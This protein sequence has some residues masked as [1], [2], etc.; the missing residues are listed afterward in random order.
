MIDRRVIVRDATHSPPRACGAPAPASQTVAHVMFLALM[1]LIV[2]GA[3]AGL[4]DLK[5]IN[6]PRYVQI[7]REINQSGSWFALTLHGVP[8]DQKPPLGFWFLA[9]VLR[10]TGDA[11]SSF[12]LRLPSVLAACLTVL[13]TY[14]LGRR[15]WGA[16]AGLIAASLLLASPELVSLAQSAKLDM[17]FTA[18]ITLALWAWLTRPAGGAPI[19]RGRALVLWGSLAAAVLTK[20]PLAILIVLPVIAADAV[21]ARSWKPL[22]DARPL[23]G[24]VIVLAPV[25]GWLFAEA[26]RVGSGFVVDQITGATLHR[27]FGKT[28]ERPLWY[29]L[30]YFPTAILPLWGFVLIG[31]AVALWRRRSSLPSSLVSL[32]VWVTVPFLVLTLARGKHTSYLLPI[33]PGCALLVGWYLED[34]LAQGRCWPRLARVFS[35]LAWFAGAASIAFGVAVLL[36]PD[37][38]WPREIHATAIAQLAMV[39]GVVL[40]GAGIWVVAD[41]HRGWVTVQGTIVAML[42]F[43][44]NGSAIINSLANATK[45]T[46][47]FGEM[48]DKLIAETGVSREVGALGRAGRA[49]HHIYGHYRVRLIDPNEGVFDNPSNLPSL[50]VGY[51]E[52]WQGLERAARAAGY[53]RIVVRSFADD[54]L[55]LY[56]RRTDAST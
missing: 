19:S 47:P 23:L 28:H 4:W 2:L 30:L 10:T 22:R 14:D 37:Y 43:V 41:R 35:G 5:G 12:A 21:R 33:L 13:L 9:A 3:T 16:R 55:R 53:R 38:F 11:V 17:M 44:L 31:A 15:Y 8:Y 27:L 52:D 20:G 26:L 24:S 48:V 45:T 25:L 39:A 56:L 46:R 32:V 49:R 34:L 18:W 54:A 42:V 40:V 7:A 6:E 29:Y 51:E 50:L 1:S 36:P